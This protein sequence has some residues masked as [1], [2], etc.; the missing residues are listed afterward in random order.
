[1]SSEGE[2][3]IILGQLF[4]IVNILQNNL[5]SFNRFPWPSHTFGDA[6]SIAVDGEDSALFKISSRSS[7]VGKLRNF[8]VRTN[9]TNRTLAGHKSLLVIQTYCVLSNL[10]PS[11][12]WN[13]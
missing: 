9:N 11:S 7:N 13:V 6:D 10:H 4:S 2:K 12:K 1:M 5:G 3:E 8:H